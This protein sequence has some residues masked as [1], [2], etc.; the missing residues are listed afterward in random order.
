MRCFERPMERDYQ[1]VR[2]Y[3]YNTRPI[4]ENENSWILSKEDLVAL[5]LPKELDWLEQHI[6]RFLRLIQCRLTLVS[7]SEVIWKVI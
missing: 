4:V 1:S 5:R 3:T 2:D 7:G 6:E